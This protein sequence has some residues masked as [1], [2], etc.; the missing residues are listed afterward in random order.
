VVFMRVALLGALTV[1]L[2]TGLPDNAR[3]TER[4]EGAA[5]TR[6]VLLGTQ[7]GPTI[8]K[9]R[10][11]PASLLVVD[12]HPYLIDA[13][14]GVSRQLQWAGFD[15]EDITDVFLTHLHLDH[16][17]GLA[18]VLGLAWTRGKPE[19]FEVYGPPGTGD[20][21]DGARAYLRDPVKIYAAQ[22]PPRPS[23][24]EFINSHDIDL[25]K[26][27]V[28]FEDERVKV[29][30]VVN[31]HYST[32]NKDSLFEYPVE[33]YA[34]R[35]DSKDRS[36]V[37]TG[38]TGP[39]AAIAELAKDADILVSEVM[40][41]DQTMK[42]LAKLYGNSSPEQM[43]RSEAHIAHMREEHLTSEDLGKLAHKA[44]VKMV[45]LSHIIMGVDEETDYLGYV[46]G[47]RRYFSGVVV[48]GQDLDQF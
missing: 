6:V 36:V 38:D 26:S 5:G 10:S 14:T 20:F 4:E 28:V 48:M 19:S 37:F 44:N 39:S 46:N 30:A 25:E 40:D 1:F 22:L 35:F 33:S 43:K 16:V 23:L 24:N 27:G 17:A 15:P 13:G 42:H 8:R 31:S 21:I 32:L 29:T 18:P 45:V 9:Y 41:I 11:Q 2:F 7:G 34:Y 12:G 47:V 3:A